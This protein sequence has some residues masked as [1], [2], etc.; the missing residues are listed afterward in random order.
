TRRTSAGFHFDLES[1]SIGIGHQQSNEQIGLTIR[2][3][4][5][6]PRR[7]EGHEETRRFIHS[8]VRDAEFAELILVR[9][10]FAED[11]DRSAK[12]T[13]RRATLLIAKAAR[14]VESFCDREC[15]SACSGR[16]CRP[17]VAAPLL[18]SMFFVL[19]ENSFPCAARRAA[20]ERTPPRPP[21]PPW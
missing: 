14:T 7:H 18:V 19:C 2:S 21:Y 16:R 13:T 5:C 4:A 8:H 12:R 6:S 10:E 15:G 9:A 17:P 20:S 11:R 1:G 3:H